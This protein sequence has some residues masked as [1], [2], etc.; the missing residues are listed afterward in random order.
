MNETR[1]QADDAQANERSV[2]E[3]SAENPEITTVTDYSA[4]GE[5]HSIRDRYNMHD[6]SFRRHYH[7]NYLKAPEDYNFYAPAYYFGYELAEENPNLT[8]EEAQEKAEQHWQ[9]R[10]ATEWNRMQDAIYY[11][12]VENRDPDLLRVHH[13]EY[14]YNDYRNSFEEHYRQALESD[15]PFEHYEPIYQYG[16]T[17]AVD[18]L[19][20]SYTWEEIEPEVLKYYETEY[21]KGEMPWEHYRDTVAYVWHGVRPY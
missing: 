3:K 1:R 15:M 21:E 12:W 14:T 7:L 2:I 11:G 19:Y 6:A 10:H 16:Y 4:M 13:A 18:P 17:L 5:Q 8:W 9:S 20:G